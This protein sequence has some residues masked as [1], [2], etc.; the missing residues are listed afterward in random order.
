MSPGVPVAEPRIIEPVAERKLLQQAWADRL[1]ALL[2]RIR[3]IQ[4]A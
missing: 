2:V 4:A 1:R 3:R